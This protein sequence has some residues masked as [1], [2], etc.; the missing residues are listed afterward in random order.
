MMTT[1]EHE[2]LSLLLPW[3][4]AGTLDAVNHAKVEAA[5]KT[6]AALRTELDIIREDEAAVLALAGVEQVPA[7]M[8]ARF[9]AAFENKLDAQQSSEATASQP[10]K[11]ESLLS[12]L[13]APLMVG[14]RLAYV[15]VAAML[16]ITVQ[17]GALVSLVRD[18]SPAQYRTVS[19]GE[20]ANTGGLRVIAR[21]A[22]D[23]TIADVRVYLAE[24]GG[25]IVD[26]PLPG[27]MFELRFAEDAAADAAALAT[28]LG[29]TGE[30][31]QLVLPG[32]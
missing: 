10:A 19:G 17:T 5:L 31:F 16:V 4:L 27:N 9:S 15:A 24:N 32:K 25:T 28:Q 20:V 21:F 29:E 14:N 11:R 6:D 18:G 7:S 1:K 8:H 22:D 13:F 26:G 12:R 2:E 3:Y 23:A 30:L